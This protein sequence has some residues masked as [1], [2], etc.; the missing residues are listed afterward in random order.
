[1]LSASLSKIIN[2][3]LYQVGWFSCVLGAAYGFPLSGALGAFALVLLHL[4]L[5]DTRKAE[6]QLA[7]C[8]CL[9]GVVI[10]SL[11]QAAGLFTFKADP[12]WPLWLPL[13]I[14][15]V[16]AQFATLFRFALHWLSGRYLLG[17]FLGGLGG[18]L[19]YWGGIRLGAASFGDSPLITLV[20]LAFVW[21]G[22]TPLLLWS[23]Q[24]LASAEGC[25]RRFF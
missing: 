21:A 8:S 23:R 24:K 3:V 10:D 6:I 11:Q 18:P 16:W 13:W 9:I 4:L 5:T 15:V 2:I 19:A 20:V 17:A 7:I 14:F 1:M 25:Y 12:L 22:V